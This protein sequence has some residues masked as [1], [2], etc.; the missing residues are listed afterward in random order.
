MYNIDLKQLI[1]HDLTRSEVMSTI[2][3]EQPLVSSMKHPRG[4]N[5]KHQDILFLSQYSFAVVN[6]FVNF[7][8][9]KENH[10]GPVH[11]V[12]VNLRP[13]ADIPCLLWLTQ[14]IQ[15]RLHPQGKPANFT[16]DV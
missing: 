6:G 11:L 12:Q 16:A 3:C 8:D 5:C 14:D 7:I 10:G 9:L 1:S 15:L 13:T 2:S 4:C